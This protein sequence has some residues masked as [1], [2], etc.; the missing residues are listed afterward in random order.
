METKDKISELVEWAKMKI[1][2]G[3]PNNREMDIVDC[4]NIAKQILSHPDLRLKFKSNLPRFNYGD[5]NDVAH[6]TV[7]KML[8]YGYESVINLAERLKE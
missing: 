6:H 8:S 5:C 1:V 4:E 3:T 2:L 7:A